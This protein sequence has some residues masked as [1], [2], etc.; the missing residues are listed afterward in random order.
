LD[1][2]FGL[3]AINRGVADVLALD[4]IDNVF[5][6]VG[7]VVADAFEIFGDQDQF[8][9][10]KDDA[11]IAHHV[12]EEFAED[13][14]AVVIH[15]IIGGQDFLGE[16][17]VAADYSVES[18]A[19]HFFGEL[20]HAR[21]VDVGL[22]ARM[23]KDPRSGLGDVDGLVADALEVVVDAGDSEHEAEIDGH[24]LM[25]REELDDAVVNFDLQFV[26]GVFLIEDAPGELFISFEDGVDG[27][28]DGT[29]AEAAHPEQSLFQFVQ[30]SFEVA[31]HENFPSVVYSPG[32]GKSRFP[33]SLGM[34]DNREHACHGISQSGR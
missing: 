24:Q 9:G 22:D 11:G 29:L 15:L 17:N 6:D 8:E 28:M 12:G 19:D 5:G 4:D 25:K 31:F 21:E 34:T 30:V 13:L 23:A 32:F 7:G 27:L 16:V 1:E 10:G 33:A 20:A 3:A 18:V 2:R 26:D 14:I